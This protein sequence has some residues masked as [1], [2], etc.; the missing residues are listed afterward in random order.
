MLL[1]S[2]VKTFLKSYNNRD[3]V[4]LSRAQNNDGIILLFHL[5]VHKLQIF[6]HYVF[7]SITYQVIL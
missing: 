3:E 7:S 5:F 1:F 4:E 2:I 6:D